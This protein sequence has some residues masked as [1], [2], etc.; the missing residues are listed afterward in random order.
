VPAYDDIASPYLN[1]GQWVI[2]YTLTADSIEAHSVI[3]GEPIPL[4]E[5]TRQSLASLS[6]EKRARAEAALTRIQSPEYQESEHRDRDALDREYRATGT[7]ASTPVTD[8]DVEAFDAFI[9]SLREARESAGL[10]LDEVASRSGIDKAQVSRLENGK[11]HDPRSRTLARYARAI[12]KRL[13][14]SLEDPQFL[15]QR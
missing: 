5:R 11:V 8:A 12:G 6:P 4:S 1:N 2:H 7:I 9:R 10:S 13:T 3:D 15:Q 14:W